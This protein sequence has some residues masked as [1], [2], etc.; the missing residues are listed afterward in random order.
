MKRRSLL[1]WLAASGCHRTA[2]RPTEFTR[3]LLALARGTALASDEQ[4]DWSVNE[5]ERIVELARSASA[6]AP[7]RSQSAVLSELL[8]GTLGFVREVDDTDLRFVLLPSVLCAA[9]AAAS[10]WAR[11]SWRWQTRWAGRRAA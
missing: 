5:L 4:V 6:Q 9:A 7:E 11:C 8:F 2:P 1:L 10:A 3:G